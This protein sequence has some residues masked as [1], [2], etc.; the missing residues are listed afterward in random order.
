MI[1]RIIIAV[2]ILTMG[3]FCTVIAEAYWEWTPKTGKWINP[4]H[5]VKATS[6]EQFKY[7]ME[8]YNSRDYDKA[9]LEFK[10]LIKNYSSSE[11]APEAQYTIGLIYEDKGEYYEAFK[12]YQKVIEEYPSTERVNEIIGREFKIANLFYEGKRR[13]VMGV[14]FIPTVDKAID[15]FRKVIENA[16]YGEYADIAQ[17]KIG[18]CHMKEKNYE[19][20]KAEFEK[21]INEYPKSSLTDDAKYQIVLA[22]SLISLNTP[23]DQEGTDSGIKVSEEFKAEYPESELKED[24]KGIKAQLKNKEAEKIFNIARFY[25]KRKK[26]TSAKIYYESLVRDYSETTWAEEAKKRLEIL[27]GTDDK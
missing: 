7:G 20:A 9:I 12:S 16:P 15:I 2:S 3:I 6:K 1:R 21:L 14:L 24:V 17:Y 25:E 26:L 5:A 27:G 22:S 13:R 19:E 11:E 4:K 8:L 23:Y 18:L 10:K